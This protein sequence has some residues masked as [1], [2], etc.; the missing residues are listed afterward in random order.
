MTGCCDQCA[1]RSWL[2]GRLAGHIEK[3]R[4]DRAAVRT[5]LALPDSD[6][7]AA[8]AGSR[9]RT[10]AAELARIDPAELLAGWKQSAVTTW[11]RHSEP[12][13]AGLLRLADPPAAI[14]FAGR[15]ERLAALLA[16]PAVAVVGARRCSADGSRLSR[17][18][19]RGCSAAGVTVVSGMA[20]GVDAA[21]HEGALE[22]GAAT[23]AVL[24]GGPE[25]A[26][27]A[28]WRV[29]HRAIAARG[30]VVSELP[31]GTPSYRW[32]FPARNRLIAAL[33]GMVVVV[34]AA[35]RSGS[36]ITAE[37]AADIGIP[38]GAVPGAPDRPLSRATNELIR[39]GSALIRDAGDVLDELLGVEA[40]RTP[41]TAIDPDLAEVAELVGR[42]VES[43]ER[44]AVEMGD[45]SGLPAALTR[46]ELL[47]IV[48]RR[49]GGRYA[50][51]CVQW[52]PSSA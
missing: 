43:V 26:Y 39:D 33:S 1:R 28:R 30:T 25:R 2:V 38:V 6:L 16:A 24:A 14:H 13:P 20:L 50:P 4:G 5:L 22:A 23:V 37:I 12:Y 9:R 7:I 42:G 15:P 11:C 8:V 52:E 35:E 31:P 46:L 34:E 10:V 32:G 21:A 17:A 51:G 41:V 29:L 40:R 36:L 18:L 19:G 44:I 27:P 47:G 48:E 49:A 45:A 3:S